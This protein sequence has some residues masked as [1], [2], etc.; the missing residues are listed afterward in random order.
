MTKAQIRCRN[1]RQ[2]FTLSLTCSDVN[3]FAHSMLPFSMPT[4]RFSSFN[5]HI[6]VTRLANVISSYGPSSMRLH[7]VTVFAPDI[8]K[9][10]PLGHNVR[11][12]NTI[13]ASD[14][15]LVLKV[16]ICFPLNISHPR[17]V[18]SFPAV[19]ANLSDGWRQTF[20]TDL[21]V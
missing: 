5:Q 11:L 15:S 6:E 3:I 7:N 18:P 10:F 8:A 1:S 17:K 21:P 19:K 13:L 20:S 12:S 16:L 14:K 9:V 2:I 4:S